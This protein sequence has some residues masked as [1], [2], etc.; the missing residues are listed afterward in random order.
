MEI[1]HLLDAKPAELSGGQRQRAAL[2]RAIVRRPNVLLLDEPLSN[3][4]ALLRISMRSE[5]KQ[6]QRRIAVTTIYVTHDQT[7]AMSL[8]DCVAVLRDGEIQ[9][10]GTPDEIYH[11]PQNL[12]VAKFMGTPPMNFLDGKILKKA[13]KDIAIATRHDRKNL[14][15][16]IRPEH[17][18]VTSPEDGIFRGTLKLVSS[19]GSEIIFYIDI[20]QYKILVK[21]FEKPG[22]SEGDKVGVTFDS[23]NVFIFD[24]NSE[25]R[26]MQ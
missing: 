22:F 8:G 11:N 15:L 12:F 16:G 25:K 24:K 6:I 4:D 14:I 3:L 7:E 21:V 9:Q 17:L 18:Q 1:I 26:K 10:S 19:L 20:A 5:L 2:G 23:R 13:Q